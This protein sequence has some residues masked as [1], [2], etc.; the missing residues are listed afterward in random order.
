[1]TLFDTEFRRRCEYLDQAA[2]RSW[3]SRF[4]GRRLDRRWA[5]GSEFVG[6]SDYTCGD[7][8]R[9]IDWPICARHDELLTRQYR[10]SEDRIVYL[11]VDCSP[12]MR[13]G[14][15]AK[16]DVA[17]RLAGALGTMALAN[18]DRVGVVAVA[19]RVVAELPPVRGRQRAFRL[20]RFLDELQTSAA[21]VKLR[22]AA[23][24]FV[25]Q[26]PQ[27]GTTV[28]ISDL[29]DPAGFEPAIDLLAQRGFPPYLLQ[30]VDERE[31]DPHLSGGVT[32]VDV[33]TGRSRRT[34]LEDLDLVN[35]RRVFQEFIASCRGYCARRSIGI[36]Q[37]TTGTPVQE[38][39]LRV[40]RTA[41]SRMYAPCDR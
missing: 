23:E 9:Y 39:V 27:R 12:G 30:V 38:S 16:F 18:L 25:Q 34:Y 35:Y 31:I 32:L 24:A 37:T 22:S 36:L 28:V 5:G 40:I 3:G 1:M 15:P 33:A 29:F 41:T 2:R 14:T 4:L 26:R 20:Y 8:F 21:P 6:H 7:D 13:L 17:R 11:L 10:G 19:D